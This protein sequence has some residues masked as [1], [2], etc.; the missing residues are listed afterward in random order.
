MA[1]PQETLAFKFIE[2]LTYANTLQQ[3]HTIK[4]LK[5][6]NNNNYIKL[7]IYFIPNKNT[8]GLFNS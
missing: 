1:T 7:A 8:K 4:Y 6:L 2:R 5:V 3:A